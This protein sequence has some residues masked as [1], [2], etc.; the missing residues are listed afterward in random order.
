MLP[1]LLDLHLFL[2]IEF[3]YKDSLSRRMSLGLK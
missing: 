2:L 1:V 3:G